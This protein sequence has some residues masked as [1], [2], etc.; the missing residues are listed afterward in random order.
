MLL[1]RS[2]RSSL[3]GM[4]W[5]DWLRIS[6]PKRLNDAGSFLHRRLGDREY[7]KRVFEFK[8]EEDIERLVPVQISSAGVED[9]LVDMGILERGTARRDIADFPRKVLRALFGH[10]R[11][12]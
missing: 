3:L 5:E 2:T 1:M 8:S 4:L 7:A 11:H 10:L 9:I 6:T 12:R